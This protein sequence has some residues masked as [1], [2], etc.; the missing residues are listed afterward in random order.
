MNPPEKMRTTIH[1]PLSK[2][3]NTSPS[4]DIY[5][6][7]L[8]AIYIDFK[9]KLGT[10]HESRSLLAPDD[11]QSKDYMLIMSLPPSFSA[12]TETM[13]PGDSVN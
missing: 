10:L 12:P 4:Y 8:G 2:F 11:E 9:A 5:S 13:P 3:E 6:L 1:G 7:V